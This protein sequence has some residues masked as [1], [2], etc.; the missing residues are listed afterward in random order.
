MKKTTTNITTG[1]LVFTLLFGLAGVHVA[2]AQ[3]P[4]D[5][6]TLRADI[7]ANE[8]RQLTGENI[9]ARSG[10][11]DLSLEGDNAGNNALLCT[12]GLVKFATNILFF[13]LLALAVLLIAWAAFLFVTA[14]AKEDNKEKARNMLIYAIV[15]L[16]VAALAQTI[17]AIA[18]GI[19]GV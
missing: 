17:P 4:A 2:Q 18:R 10:G 15:G 6:C 1:L 8:A 5:S 16:V 9:G 12:Y 13:V 3:Q 14:G 11:Q 19:I 7:T